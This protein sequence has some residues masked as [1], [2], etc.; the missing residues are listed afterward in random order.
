MRHD[1][2]DLIYVLSDHVGEMG[3]AA[4]STRL[5]CETLIEL[6]KGVR[7]F[8]TLPPDHATRQKLEAK[9]IEIVLPCINKG[10]RWSIPQKLIALQLFV[11]ALFAPPTLIHSQGL[12]SEA[13]YLLQLPHVAPIY[14]WENTEALPHVKFVDKKIHRHLHKA[15]TVLAT[16]KTIANN[17]RDTYAYEGDIKLLPLWTD[18]PNENG[19]FVPHARNS[20][21]LYL[22]RFD[23]DKG[24]NYLFEAFRMIQPIYPNANL[25]LCGEGD[26]ELVHR[27]AGDNPGVRIQGRVIGEQLEEVINYCDA[28]VLPSL[29]EGYPLSLLEAC[30]RRTPIISTTVG[31]IPELF[32]GRACALLVCPRDTVAL[33]Q[34]MAKILSEC[35]ALYSERCTDAFKLFAEVNST[36]NI[37]RSLLEAYGLPVKGHS[38]A[39]Q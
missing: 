39:H 29:H 18:Q 13:R 23:R 27:L 2:S 19:T 7:L 35:V 28:M 3:G 14:L 38:V 4:K 12:S 5:L 15:T 21:L 31:S 32:G 11:Q 25:S 30:A 17:V 6:G 22:G 16:S 33:S 34:A 1:G 9:N 8:V 20:N 24:L 36:S 26:I 10:W 37:H